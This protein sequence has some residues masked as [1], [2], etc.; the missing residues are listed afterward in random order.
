MGKFNG[1]DGSRN[2]NNGGTSGTEFSKSEIIKVILASVFI[3]AFFVSATIIALKY[4]SPAP[5]ETEEQQAAVKTGVQPSDLQLPQT[6]TN[7]NDL[8]KTIE[9]NEQSQNATL[10]AHENKN[11]RQLRYYT[12]KAKNIKFVNGEI[13]GISVEFIFDTGASDI[14]LNAETIKRLGIKEFSKT[15]QYK[16][17]GGIVTA[18]RFVCATVKIGDFEIKDVDCA[19]NPSASENLLGGTFLT[20]FNYYIDELAS[21]ITL[22]PKSEKA[23]LIDGELR[24]P[25]GHGYIE[26]DGKKY[27]YDE[28]RLKKVE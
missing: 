11:I 1:Y 4:V 14:A 25:K 21:T 26:I 7:P 18:Y 3:I 19:Y 27:Q 17:A 15:A 2:S 5:S 10:K 22:V 6:Q 13:N 23:E 12:K 20:H 16:T 8:P 28:G 24:I 9:Q